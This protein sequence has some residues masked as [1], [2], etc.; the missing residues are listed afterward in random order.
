M[1]LL[2]FNSGINVITFYWILI[3]HYFAE[4]ILTRD[5]D[6]SASV[7]IIDA[8]QNQDTLTIKEDQEWSDKI[9]PRF[10]DTCG[11]SSTGVSVTLIHNS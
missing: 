1:L 7:K 5:R 10:K 6:D 11:K 4:S 8:D 9:F 2:I 3:L